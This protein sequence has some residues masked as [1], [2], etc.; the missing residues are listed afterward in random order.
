M[1]ELILC[2]LGFLIALI[3]LEVGLIWALG[4][5]PDDIVICTKTT[6]TERTER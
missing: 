6:I 1:I 3:A 5:L 4:K 2:V